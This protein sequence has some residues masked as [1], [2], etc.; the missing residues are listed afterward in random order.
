MDTPTFTLSLKQEASKLGFVL[1]GVAPALTPALAVEHL[2]QWLMAGYAGHM[3]YLAKR[4]PAYANPE[5][6][7]PNA[8]SVL[9][10]ALPYRT[11]QPEKAQPGEGNIASYAWG[12]A[13]YHDIIHAKLEE[14]KS[15]FQS[16]IPTAQVRGI[17][18]SAPFLERDFAQLA[19]LGWIG[20]HTL[21]LNREYGSWFFLAALLTDVPLAYDLPFPADYCG[22]CTACL[23][24]C[25]TQAFP[26]PYVLDARLCISYLT[27]EHKPPLPETSAEMLYDWL[28]G[29]DICQQVCPWNRKVTSLGE[30]EFHPQEN[31]NPIQLLELFELSPEEFRKRF[32][33]TPLWRV[34]Q[35]G[36]LANAAYVLGNQ[37]YSP[38][39]PYLRK[40]ADNPNDKLR[41]ACRWAIQKIELHAARH[42]Q[43]IL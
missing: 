6:V 13:D 25:P 14:L 29:C 24:A 20:K 43:E 4:L 27:I 33:K 32:R 40:F 35:T 37:H 28:F 8:R 12:V 15:W 3:E 31:H 10:L 18:D 11:Q 21:L 19:G 34:K 2:Q 1:T 39:L 16:Q 41:L 5:L 30:E 7:L 36:V 22:S 26:Q 17:V 23:D 42:S 9:M 38:A